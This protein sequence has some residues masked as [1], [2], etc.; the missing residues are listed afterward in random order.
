MVTQ[1]FWQAT[2]GKA[3]MHYS[4]C[5]LVYQNR[6]LLL[7]IYLKLTVLFILFAT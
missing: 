5:V 7:I 4:I 6:Y 3:R 1:C 2:Q